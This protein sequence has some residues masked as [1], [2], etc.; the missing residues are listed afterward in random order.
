MPKSPV[1]A[2]NPALAK[3]LNRL[4][5]VFSVIVVLVVASLRRFHIDTAVD[6]RFLA[7]LHS[8]L[9]ALTALGLMLAYYFVKQQKILWHKRIMI[10]NM[11]L[12]GLFL[13]SYIIYHLTTPE[14]RYCHVGNIRYV[15]FFILITHVILASLILPV[16]LFTFIRAF[17]GQIEKHRALARWTFPVW[18]YIAL[19]GPLAYLMLRS[20]M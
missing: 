15:Y 7:P 3:K 16:V 20:C 18:L 6:F 14:T 2:F 11:V 5:I 9:N 4:A 19:S 1:P 8:S 13:I 10:L 12:S 17:T